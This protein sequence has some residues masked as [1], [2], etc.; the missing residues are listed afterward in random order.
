M[1][2]CPAIASVNTSRSA[3][4]SSSIMASSGP[5]LAKSASGWKPGVTSGPSGV[6]VSVPS[7]SDGPSGTI[8]LVRETCAIENLL[9]GW[10]GDRGPSGWG[11]REH[12][13]RRCQLRGGPGHTGSAGLPKGDPVLEGS[14]RG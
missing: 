7:G 1:H 4:L 11:H 3:P 5:K 10:Y 2:S 13:E 12:P 9:H 6:R 14:G 8:L